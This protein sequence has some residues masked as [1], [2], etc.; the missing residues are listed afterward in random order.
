MRIIQLTL[1]YTTQIDDE[2]YARVTKYSWHAHFASNKVYARARINYK[3]T[4]LHRYILNAPP[5]MQVDHKNHDTLDNRRD[6]LKITT[7]S[8][9]QRNRS[10]APSHSKTGVRGVQKLP[11]G[12]YRVLIQTQH[13][14]VY[15]TSEEA[16]RVAQEVRTKL[17]GDNT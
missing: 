6:N 9:N 13:Y 16:T 8:Q 4:Y 11:S 5:D 15:D 12:R 10:G 7:P 17:Y 14:G 2:D 1:G 3:L